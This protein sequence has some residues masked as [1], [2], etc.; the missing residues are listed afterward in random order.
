MIQPS[1]C[2]SVK[3]V[4]ASPHWVPV[5]IKQGSAQ[6][7]AV[8]RLGCSGW[9]LLIPTRSEPGVPLR[10]LIEQAQAPPSSAAPEALETTT[11]HCSPSLGEEEE[12]SRKNMNR[13]SF[14]GPRAGLE[15]PHVRCV[16]TFTH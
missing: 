12:G 8:T 9:Q 5:G 6:D 14:G 7:R 2:P 10:V 1:V 15:A 11:A 4:T 16:D 13:R 3:G